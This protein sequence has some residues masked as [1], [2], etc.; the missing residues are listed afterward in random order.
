MVFN[1]HHRCD[2][3]P[4]SDPSETVTDILATLRRRRERH[5]TETKFIV[6]FRL[7]TSNNSYIVFHILIPQRLC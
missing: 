5:S 6:L 3:H 2:T 4:E 1:W 7:V